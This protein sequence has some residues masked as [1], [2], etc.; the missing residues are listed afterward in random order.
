MSDPTRP[1]A[2]ILE[3]LPEPVPYDA[4]RR[5]AEIEADIVRTRAELG[6]TLV[7]LER[8]LVP[9]QFLEKGVDML[10][11]SMDGNLGRVGETLRENPL[12][13]VLIAGGVGWLILSRAGVHPVDTV[14]QTRIR[15]VARRVGGLAGDA[16]G[17]V[18]DA[19]HRVGDAAGRVRETVKAR[20]SDDP[21]SD[22]YAYARPKPERGRGE[23]PVGSEARVA[24]R[25]KSA[26]DLS[27]AAGRAQTRFQELLEE[28]PL[29]VGAV[30]F[31][32]GAVVA[33]AL[34]ATRLGDGTL[35]EARD[36]LFGE[37]KRRARQAAGVVDEALSGNDD[38]AQSKGETRPES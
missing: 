20:M 1:P 7:A 5:P 30:G 17:R 2:E 31:L 24:E 4:N 35:G 38:G 33:L 12:P 27:E 36:R 9:R 21:A 14:R 13:L 15:D 25:G 32:L 19:A 16:A 6:E 10:R 22:R 34:P 23:S 3:P 11:D 29:A 8:K 37:A 18:S 26:E 28:H